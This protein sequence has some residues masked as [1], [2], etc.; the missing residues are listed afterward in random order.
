MAADG[1]KQMAVDT[2]AGCRRLRCRI[3]RMLAARW[4]DWRSLCGALVGPVAPSVVS[5]VFEHLAR[6]KAV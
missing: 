6:A 2:S 5:G 1:E 3:T 4:P